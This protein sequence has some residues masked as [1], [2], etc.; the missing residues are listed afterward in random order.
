MNKPEITP[1]FTRGVSQVRLDL[2]EVSPEN[3][4]GTVEQDASFE[5][6]VSSIGEVG[7]LVPIVVREMASGRFQLVDGERRFL[8]AQ[9][10]RLPK[11]P[12]H[13]LK[14]SV[15]KQNLRRYMFHLHM[16][17]EQWEPLAQCKSLAEMYPEIQDGLAIAEKRTWAERIAGETWMNMR[18]AKDRVHVL[19]WP[20]PLKEKIYSFDANKPDRDIYSYVL[21][22]EASIIEPSAKVFGAFY[23]HGRPV[24]QRANEV[25][26]SLFDKTV[27]GIEAGM[28]TSRD[29]IR[30][31]EPLFQS[32]LNQAQMKVAVRIFTDLVEKPK[33][34]YD[35]AVILMETRLPELLAERPPRPQ[36]LIGLVTSLAE[37]LK[38][39]KPEYLNVIRPE[40]TR[41]RSK[42]QLSSALGELAAEATTL[43][44]KIE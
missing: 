3:P 12:A 8:A 34:S 24:D 25:R 19:A 15:N 39:Y 18:L 9:R 42:V 33:F 23:N 29:Q 16:T 6:L 11:V 13:V 14:G 31:V 44:D 10:L 1:E 32:N 2:I 5:R 28:V 41:R 21:A 40:P 37:T 22:I 27:S 38:A 36:R 43:K 17:R 20:A 26:A 35:D 4:R 7:I 30:H